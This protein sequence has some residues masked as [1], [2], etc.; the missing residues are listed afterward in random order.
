MFP[1][2][3]KKLKEKIFETSLKY[4]YP[5]VFVKFAKKY[6]KKQ[7]VKFN[8]QQLFKLRIWANQLRELKSNSEGDENISAIDYLTYQ[9]GV[10]IVKYAS[11]SESDSE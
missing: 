9:I 3:G 5:I 4:V 7:D 8:D 6:V 2:L 11:E 10:R 1:K